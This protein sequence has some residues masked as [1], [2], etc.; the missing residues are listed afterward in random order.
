MMGG[1]EAF[2]S[3]LS[4]PED[5]FEIIKPQ[6]IQLFEDTLNERQSEKE[7]IALILSKDYDIDEIQ[8]ERHSQPLARQKISGSTPHHIGY[9]K[10]VAYF[11]ELAVRT[12][13]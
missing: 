8:K 9:G 4:L 12:D 1:L 6:M 2:E 7:I 10:R 13:T 3:L 11:S 5:Q